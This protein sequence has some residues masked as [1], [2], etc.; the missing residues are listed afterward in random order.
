[1][2]RQNDKNEN[3]EPK[4]DRDGWKAKRREQRRNKGKRR[5]FE[6]EHMS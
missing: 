5:Q 3:R 4:R 6:R 1:M 2:K